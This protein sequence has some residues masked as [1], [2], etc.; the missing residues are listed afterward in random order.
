VESNTRVF[1]FGSGTESFMMLT[2][3]LSG[4]VRYKITADNSDASKTFA[5]EFE[6]DIPRDEWVHIAITQEDTVF[7]LYLNGALV[8]A[9]VNAN[10]VR[11][12]DLGH[13]SQNY[14]GKSQWSSDPYCSHSYDDFRIYSKAL[15]DRDIAALL[16]PPPPVRVEGVSLSE[17]RYEL[18]VGEALLLVALVDPVNAANKNVEWSSDNPLVA[19]VDTGLVTAL[20]PG[21]AAITA[22]TEDGRKTAVC[23]VRVVESAKTAATPLN[24]SA[25]W[26]YAKNGILVVNSPLAEAVE[27]Y[28]ASG[29]KVG[30]AKKQAGVSKISLAGLPPQLLIV[31]GSSGWTRKVVLS[32]PL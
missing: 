16:P 21:T 9:E 30:G 31:R 3:Y 26:V 17:T 22:A 18:E 25:V 29:S 27:V 6:C 10:A 28:A 1:D 7:N 24:A 8:G 19:S 32:S 20:A 15:S 2:P 12:S 23:E 14:L 4:K 5:A 11:P 13:T